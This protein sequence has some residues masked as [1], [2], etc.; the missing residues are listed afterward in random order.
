MSYSYQVALVCTIF[1]GQ[2]DKEQE[3][4]ERLAQYYNIETAVS[5]A[6]GKRTETKKRKYKG[7]SEELSEVKQKVKMRDPGAKYNLLSALDSDVKIEQGI[8]D[9]HIIFHYPNNGE[10]TVLIEKLHKIATNKESGLIEI[11]ADNESATYVMSEEEFIEMRHQLIK[12]G[13][14]DR[15]QLTQRWWVTRDPVHW[16]PHNGSSS[17]ERA[18]KER[19]EIN[20]ENLRYSPEDLARIDELITIS[21][22]SK[23]CEGR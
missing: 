17:W 19:F 7:A 18:L 12:E 6:S 14:V 13:K 22:E 1:D 4:R 2:T 21:I 15:T 9:G 23:K 8:I 5:N 11:R 16:I 20:T 10:G 3:I